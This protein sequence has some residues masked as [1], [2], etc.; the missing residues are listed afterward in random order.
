[1]RGTRN[2]KLSNN[3]QL[4]SEEWELLI[5]WLIQQWDQ[6]RVHLLLLWTELSIWSTSREC[7]GILSTDLQP[8]WSVWGQM[9]PVQTLLIL[10]PSQ[11]Q[12]WG[13]RQHF[14]AQPLWYQ[15]VKDETSRQSWARCGNE[16]PGPFHCHW[17]PQLICSTTE[18]LRLF[19]CLLILCT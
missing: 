6:P 8:W 7:F 10:F 16:E 1:M 15:T 14:Q 18:R 12:Q 2:L 13:W 9:G 5:C 19:F 11:T 4:I 17:V 3:F